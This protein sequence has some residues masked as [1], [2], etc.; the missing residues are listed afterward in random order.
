MAIKEYN[1]TF[2]SKTN[3][4]KGYM[5]IEMKLGDEEEEEDPLT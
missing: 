4:S 1:K 3:S 5:A 2:K